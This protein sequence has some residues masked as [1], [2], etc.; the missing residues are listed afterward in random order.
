MSRTLKELE[1]KLNARIGCFIASMGFGL[2]KVIRLDFINQIR[3]QAPQLSARVRI[4]LVNSGE[5]AMRLHGFGCWFEKTLFV[6]VCWGK[7]LS[8][9]VKGS[10]EMLRQ[11][12][13]RITY[14]ETPRHSELKRGSSTGRSRS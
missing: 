13:I 9:T 11:N 4:N 8:A 10:L 2:T 3:I 7:G 1:F 12:L 6:S 5:E 14:L